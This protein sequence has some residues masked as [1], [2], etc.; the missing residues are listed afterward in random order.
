MNHKKGKLNILIVHQYFLD[1]GG[2][3]GARWNE[4]SRFWSEAGHNVTVLAGMVDYNTGKK[5]DKYKWRFIKK[6]KTDDNVTV[7]RCH[8]SQRYNS[9]FIGRAW[10]YFSFAFSSIIAGLF[11]AKRP[12]IIVS[13]S[14]PLT[15]S[16][17]MNWLGWLRRC[18]TI[19]EVRDLWPESAIDTGVLKPGRLANILYKMEAKAYH[20]SKWINVLTPAFKKKLI[21][22]KGIAPDKIS[23]IPNGADPDFFIP[24]DR[25]NAVRRE[26]GLEN[27]FVVGYFGA[28]GRANRLSQL[29]DVAAILQ[30]TEPDIQILLVGGGMEKSDLVERAR[31]E[32]LSNV[33]FVDPVAKNEVGNYVNATDVCTAVLMKNDTFKT[34][35]PNKLF[36]YMCCSRPT[37]IG[38]DGVAKDLVLEAKAGLFAE[39]ENPQAF[40]D[41]V[42]KIKNNPQLAAEMGRSGREHVLEHFT[43]GKLA[44]QYLDIVESIANPDA[45]Q[46]Q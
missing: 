10:A 3:G 33:T 23:M 26:L 1:S 19:F 38:I 39:P 15:V 42:L 45:K 8:V 41:A 31:K 28:H 5:I 37:I 4:F 34:V 24:G 43:R 11:C 27:K 44:E 29:L 40:I 13:T 46:S 25:Q 36:D 16:V 18:P 21:D 35:Y 12:D 2:A 6:E 7:L 22:N 20:Y 32:Q 30:N 14:P 9:S 17:T